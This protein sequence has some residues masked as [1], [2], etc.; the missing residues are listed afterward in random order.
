MLKIKCKI[1][2]MTNQEN[3]IPT[4]NSTGKPSCNVYRSAV[5]ARFE[6][7]YGWCLKLVL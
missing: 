6:Y 4:N 2:G 3:T 1:T 5:Q 7:A